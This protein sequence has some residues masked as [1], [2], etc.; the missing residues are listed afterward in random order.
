MSA[1]TATTECV[2][3]VISAVRRRPKT[4]SARKTTAA[5]KSSHG[6]SA[7]KYFASMRVKSSE[8]TMPPM[9]LGP[10]KIASQRRARLISRRY[11][12]ALASEPGTRATVLVAL[13]ATA[14]CASPSGARAAVSTGKVSSVPPPAIELTTPAAIAERH[15]QDRL[16]DTS[17]ML[18]QSA[19][20]EFR[21]G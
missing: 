9:R 5:V 8:P 11:P 2:S 4:V 21:L 18:L 15:N 14:A 7:E 13:A 10:A 12:Q 16:P 6:T 1:K 19:C 20:W 3:G 17:K